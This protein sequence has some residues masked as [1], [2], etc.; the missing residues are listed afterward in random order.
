MI[1]SSL[2]GYGPEIVDHSV[3]VRD[4]MLLSARIKELGYENSKV[5]LQDWYTDIKD[6]VYDE[7]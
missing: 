6:G 3:F 5:S 1:M 2:H 4:V 7:E